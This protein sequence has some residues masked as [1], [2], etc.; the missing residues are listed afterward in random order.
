MTTD[1]DSR[2][3]YRHF[4]AIP[5]RWMDNDIYGH[6]NNV[7]YYSYFDT[8][9]NEYLIAEGG[10]D[11]HKAAIIGV[12]VETMC[13]FRKS[14]AFPHIVDA[15]LRVGKLGNSSV[16]YEVG[17][18]AAGDVEVAATGHF[19]HVFVERATM[20]PVPIPDPLRACMERLLTA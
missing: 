11:I 10:F 12:A 1:I 7:V 8:V 17:L 15:G 14:L 13:K 5:T 3:K 16:R 9:I 20:K 2:D 6:V 18:F 4:L 19:V